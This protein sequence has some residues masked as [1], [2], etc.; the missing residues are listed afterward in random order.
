[1]SHDEK[2]VVYYN[3]EF[4]NQQ[5]NPLP[6]GISDN[7]GE[8]IIKN[9]QDW[10]MSVV[11]F[12]ATNLHLIPISVVEMLGNDAEEGILS[13]TV[14]TFTISY[15]G[16]DYVRNVQFDRYVREFDMGSI[17]SYQEFLNRF[18]ICIQDIL[19]IQ[20]GVLPIP[21]PVSI[22]P[23][24][25]YEPKTQLITMYFEENW[26]NPD[27]K[28]F[29]NIESHNYLFSLPIIIKDFNQING[30]DVQINFNAENRQ[31][32]DNLSGSKRANYPEITNIIPDPMISISQEA[33][34]ISSWS[35]IRSIFLTSSSL[36]IYN[37]FVDNSNSR[38]F[39]NNSSAI[40]SDFILSVPDSNPF[41]D[42]IKLEYLPQAEYRM[43]ALR[44][45]QEIK[46]INIDVFYTLP[47]GRNIQLLMEP[48][49]IF[50]VKLMFRKKKIL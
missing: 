40:I 47:N 16:I 7:R 17:K 24:F 5:K 12:D 13:N 42:R 14:C 18:N 29:M 19:D 25:V 37:E 46:R 48:K 11:R 2:T 33:I 10:E 41:S 49:A 31:N 21:P 8:A 30:K 20:I 34:S 15:M 36:P 45:K 23:K 43:I 26:K 3:A 27:I 6:V 9:P 1:M 39:S 38:S 50:S 32:T 4:Q 35:N 44:G 28:L 22:G